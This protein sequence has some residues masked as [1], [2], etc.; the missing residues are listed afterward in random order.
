MTLA[1]ATSMVCTGLSGFI[2][3]SN[4]V[5][6]AYGSVTAQRCRHQS[7][8]RARLHLRVANTRLRQQR[9][10]LSA[11]WKP[12]A[13]RLHHVLQHHL[14]AAVPESSKVRRLLV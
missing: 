7:G 1:T 2:L 12:G 6:P 8:H 11:D 5:T 13:V 10:R 4:S 14:C 3:G 9:L